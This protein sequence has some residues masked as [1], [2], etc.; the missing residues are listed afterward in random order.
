MSAKSGYPKTRKAPFRGLGFAELQAL[1]R[2][3]AFDVVHV[4]VKAALI[5]VIK[6]EIRLLF[7]NLIR[8]W[9]CLFW[10]WSLR[11]LRLV[12]RS[13]GGRSLDRRIALGCCSSRFVCRSAL[14]GRCSL[15]SRFLWLIR[16]WFF[17]QTGVRRYAHLDT[18]I[19]TKGIQISVNKLTLCGLLCAIA[20]NTKRILGSPIIQ[21]ILRSGSTFLAG[22]C[23][24]LSGFAHEFFDQRPIVVPGLVHTIDLLYGFPIP[25]QA[26][27]IEREARNEFAL[28]GLTGVLRLT[29]GG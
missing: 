11:L 13:L 25:F 1:A 9:G 10:C 24:P 14:A 19:T 8:L 17:I 4:H 27:R 7:D 22:N 20:Q 16:V 28:T 6:T 21:D 18:M 23:V 29:M 5:K 26:D 2:Q 3:L 15:G 12:S